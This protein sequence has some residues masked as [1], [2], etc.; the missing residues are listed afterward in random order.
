MLASTTPVS[1]VGSDTGSGVASYDLR[2]RST[3]YGG[4][5]SRW[6]Y[7]AGW[8]RTTRTAFTSPALRPGRTY[9]FETRAHDVAGNRSAWS[10]TRCVTRVLDDTALDVSGGWTRRSVDGYYQHTVTTATAQGSAASLAGTQSRRLAIVA[11]TCPTCGTVGIFIGGTTVATFDLRTSA[12]HRRAVL[13]VPGVAFRSGP[14]VVRV[15]SRSGR[16]ELDGV[17]ISSV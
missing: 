10:A 3:T 1:V 6:Q 7:P 2:Y 5:T 4:T 9:C 15:L 8:Q 16:V 14:L 13:V 17:G 11:T 12:V